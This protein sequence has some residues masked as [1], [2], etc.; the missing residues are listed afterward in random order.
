MAGNLGAAKENERQMLEQAQK[1]T[2]KLSD[3]IFIFIQQK[4]KR[5]RKRLRIL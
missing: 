1:A 3:K 4:D 2:R 5:A